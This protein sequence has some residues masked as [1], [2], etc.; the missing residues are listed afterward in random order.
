ML[1]DSSLEPVCYA[2]CKCKALSPDIEVLN[3]SDTTV[4]SLLRS[5]VITSTKKPSTHQISSP[6]LIAAA[7]SSS[8]ASFSDPQALEWFDVVMSSEAQLDIRDGAS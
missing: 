5:T 3:L 1:L 7:L 8:N 4:V 2:I 6:R